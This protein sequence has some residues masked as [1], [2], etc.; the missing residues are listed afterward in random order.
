MNAA[1][2]GT[3]LQAWHSRCVAS[4]HASACGRRQQAASHA[5]VGWFRCWMY[6]SRL[7]TH[8]CILQVGIVSGTVVAALLAALV[9]I[10]LLWRRAQRRRGGASPMATNSRWSKSACLLQSISVMR[11]AACASPSPHFAT[12]PCAQQRRMADATCTAR[13]SILC[14]ACRADH[15][16]LTFWTAAMR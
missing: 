2:V 7:Q 8:G 1:L 15:A 11:R 12:D 13:H 6:A 14:S 5:E 9:G 16:E 4:G 10:C 3:A